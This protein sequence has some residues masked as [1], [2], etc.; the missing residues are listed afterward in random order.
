MLPRQSQAAGRVTI[1][2][3]NFGVLTLLAAL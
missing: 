3:T 1:E 2:S